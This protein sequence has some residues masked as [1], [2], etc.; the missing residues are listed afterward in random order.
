MGKARK[1]TPEQIVN[2]QRQVEVAVAS[3]EA[4]ITEQTYYRWRKEYGGLKV[5][6][7]KRLKELE[8]EN[9]KLKRLVATQPG[10]ADPS[11]HRPGKLL[12]PERC[13]TAV[14]LARHRGA[15]ERHAC[16]LVHQPR[17]MQRYQPTQRN[18]EDAL[19]RAIITLAERYGRYG[20]RRITI[21][22]REAGWRVGKDRVE[23]IWRREGLKVPQKIRPQRE[24]RL[25][26]GG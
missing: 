1:H 12:S 4:G 20:Y 26:V 19:T 16:Q 6:Q 9:S 21:K 5:D 23:R 18:D 25:L 2:V 22:L 24:R 3:R 10:Q 11:G 8:Q 15:S 7:A 13:R 14:E 17:G